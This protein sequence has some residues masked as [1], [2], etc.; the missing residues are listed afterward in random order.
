MPRVRRGSR[1][2]G[3]G[4]GVYGNRDGASDGDVHKLPGDPDEGP[5]EGGEIEADKEAN[6]GASLDATEPQ[7]ADWEECWVCE[8]RR[9]LVWLM[10]E[11]CMYKMFGET[12]M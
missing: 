4:E 5:G 3:G 9:E 1:K 6:R 8:R 11:E 2:P 7:E 10:C 12:R